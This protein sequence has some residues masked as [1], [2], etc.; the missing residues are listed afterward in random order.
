MLQRGDYQQ[1]LVQAALKL[2]VKI[3]VGADVIGIESRED[4]KE[5]VQLK[6]GTSVEG[7]VVIGADG[8]FAVSLPSCMFWLTQ[9]PSQLRS[10]VDNTKP[11]FLTTHKSQKAWSCSVPCNF[12]PRR[13]ERS[14]E[15]KA[16]E[17]DGTS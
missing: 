9:V 11:Y 1:V 7:D 5:S 16:G 2:G 13:C 6:D 8:E 15:R 3:M 4:G 10:L 12:L 14:A 17:V